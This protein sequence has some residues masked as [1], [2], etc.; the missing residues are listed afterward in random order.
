MKGENPMG[1]LPDDVFEKILNINILDYAVN[2]GYDLIKKGNEVKINDH[3]GLVID[4]LKNRWN[5]LSDD[6]KEA[7]GGIIQFVMYLKNLSKGDA[8]HELA[9]YANIHPEPCDIA[10]DYVKKARHFEKSNDGIFTPPQKAENYRRIFAYLVKTRFIDPVIVSYYVKQH[11]LY[12]DEHHNCC[13]CGFDENGEIKSISKRGTYDVP[14][15]EPFKGL[16]RNSD[17]K[18]PFAHEGKGNRALFYEAAI[19]MLS[20]QTIKR[21]F[22]DIHQNKDDHYVALSGVAHIGVLYYLETHQNVDTIVFCTDNDEP[23]IKIIAEIIDRVEEKYPQKYK[24]D[25]D[26]PPLPHKD[27]NK[28]LEHLNKEKMFCENEKINNTWDNER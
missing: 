4:P 20:Y 16:E 10:I 7:G 2:N 11:K 5:C 21:Q 12:E 23:G 28:V 15:K 8:I 14:G 17:K 18:Y 26:L 22:G 3:G 13:F 9:T 19:D 6:S 24:Y 25:Y 27:W 1:R